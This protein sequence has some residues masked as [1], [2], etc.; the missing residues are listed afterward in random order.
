MFS[1]YL[2]AL[3]LMLAVAAAQSG[4]YGPATGHPKAGDPAPELVFSQVLSAPAAGSWTQANL[5]GQVTV[6]GF[7]TLTSPNARTV[8]AWNEVVDRFTGKHVQ[9]VW[10]TSED[11]RTLMPALARHPVKGWVL[12]DPGGASAKAFGL[13]MP[14]NV[15]IGPDGKIVGFRDGV[16]PDAQVL[17]AV[18][19]RRVVLTRPTPATVTN[20]QENNLVALDSTPARMPRAEDYRPR[21]PASDSVHITPSAA[22]ERGNFGGPDYWV[23]RGVTVKEAIEEIYGLNAIRIEVPRSLDNAKRYDFAMLV[24]QPE[25]REEMKERFKQALQEYFH[26]TA[27]Q[28]V[29]LADVYVVSREPGR[30]PP[31][32]KQ[33]G[34]SKEPG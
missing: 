10:I 32:E 9:F 19:A 14:V 24:P 22:G 12:Y 11:Q 3:V 2:S 17:N 23:L 15:Y 16:V 6:V 4:V 21:F 27:G 5:S 33:S 30:N 34:L 8:A 1:G 29:R 7:F 31:V 25:P 18:L 28:E 13:D 20:F 26:L